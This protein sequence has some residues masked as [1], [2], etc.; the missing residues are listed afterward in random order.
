MNGD[1]EITCT[2]FL[3]VMSLTQNHVTSKRLNYFV[4]ISFSHFFDFYSK[5]VK[6]KTS[7]T[8]FFIFF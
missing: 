7:K 5:D 8:T 1:G 4:K 6:N 2:L 3:G